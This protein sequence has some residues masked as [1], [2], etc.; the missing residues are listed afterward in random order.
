VI[1][2]DAVSVSV[3]ALLQRGE[4]KAAVTLLEQAR[5]TALANEDVTALWQVLETT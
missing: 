4:V 5:K 1:A 2:E 3:T